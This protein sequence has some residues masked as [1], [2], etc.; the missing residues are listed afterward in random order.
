MKRNV[1]LLFSLIFITAGVASA[2]TA[3]KTITNADLEKYRVQREKSEADYRANYKKLG[4]PSP[5]ELE[6]QRAES[7]VQAQKN[8]RQAAA[9]AA[10]NQESLQS[11]AD[12][13]KFEIAN[14]DA[15]INYLS[16]LADNL[17]NNNSVFVGG[18]TTILGGGIASYGYNRG[19]HR[20]QNNVTTYQAPNVQAAINNAASAPNPYFGTPLY[21]TGIKAVVGASGGYRRGGYGGRYY[22][23]GFAVPYAANN[24]SYEGGE[25][26]SRLVYLQQ[27][28]AGLVA[29]LNLLA[30]E[31]RRSGAKIY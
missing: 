29:Q 12:Q 13:L 16:E 30:D 26:V 11:Q 3:R 9:Q 28:R 20:P 31:A 19:F 21:P 22:G 5:E 1:L 23:D 4:M 24:N 2:Q 17:P 8:I 6:R 10:Q 18:Q 27:A 25:I 15:Q 14:L 7:L